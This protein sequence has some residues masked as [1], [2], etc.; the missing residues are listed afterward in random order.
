MIS[1]LYIKGEFEMLMDTGELTRSNK[2]LILNCLFLCH[3]SVGLMAITI[4]ISES[5]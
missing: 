5:E 2:D 4:L 1:E 3:N